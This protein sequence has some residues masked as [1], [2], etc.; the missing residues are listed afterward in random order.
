MVR[1]PLLGGWR[2]RGARA[3]GDT[4]D[5]YGHRRGQRLEALARA[6]GGGCPHA[7]DERHSVGERNR[8]RSRGVEVTAHRPRP[9]V[10]MRVRRRTAFGELDVPAIEELTAWRDSHQHSRVSLFGDADSCGSL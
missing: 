7:L 3:D 4:G 2:K 9:F 5:G 1:D 10:V 6:A 8:S